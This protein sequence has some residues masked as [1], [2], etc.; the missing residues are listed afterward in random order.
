ME[1]SWLQEAGQATGVP[2]A[3]EVLQTGLKMGY[4]FSNCDKSSLKCLS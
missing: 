2:V 4:V 3:D 1:E